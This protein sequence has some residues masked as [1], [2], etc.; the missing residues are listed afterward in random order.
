MLPSLASL[1]NRS[2]K[3]PRHKDNDL[4]NSLPD[5][6]KRLLLEKVE[7]DCEAMQQW[8][9]IKSCDEDAWRSACTRQQFPTKPGHFT[10][11]AWF[12]RNCN[13]GW[14]DHIDYAL[15]DASAKGHLEEVRQLLH[16]G[17]DVHHLNGV[18]LKWASAKGHIDVVRLLLDR[19]ANIHAGGERAFK[20]ACF[21][22]HLGVVRLL[23]DRGADIH[24]WGG[25]ALT[26]ASEQGHLEVV[27]LLLDLGVDPNANDHDPL[28]AAMTFHRHEVM[29]LLRDR[30][31]T[32]S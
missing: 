1:P 22:G 30:G 7:D 10:W 20:Q 11:R 9:Q 14:A 24:T 15:R 25:H 8:C 26:G 19:G 4:F 31:A 21:Y 32:I 18:T 17:A 12:R 27:R 3:T 13:P 28:L 23:L 2:L 6:I 5:D 16:Y 29:R